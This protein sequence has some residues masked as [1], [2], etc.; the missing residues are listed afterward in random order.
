MIHKYTYTSINT[1]VFEQLFSNYFLG[2]KKGLPEK[3]T[4]R[5]NQMMKTIKN[6]L[7]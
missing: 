3:T 6:I 5:Q 2:Y 7:D 1:Q 4:Q